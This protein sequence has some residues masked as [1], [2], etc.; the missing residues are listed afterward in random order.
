MRCFVRLLR[1]SLNVVSLYVIHSY[2]LPLHV[3]TSS[4]KLALIVVNHRLS[5]KLTHLRVDET[6]SF[7]N[8]TCFFH[9]SNSKGYSCFMRIV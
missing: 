1:N 5:S 7:V 9:L 3:T 6:T 2:Y 8:F 4:K